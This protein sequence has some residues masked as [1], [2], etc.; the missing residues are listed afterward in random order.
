MKFIKLALSFCTALALLPAS[1]FAQDEESLEVIEARIIA[2]LQSARSDIAYTDFKT[3]AIEG[4]YQI[5][6]SGSTVLYV[7]EDGEHF[8][9]GEL[10]QIQPGGFVNATEVQ[11][12]EERRIQLASLDTDSMIIFPAVGESKGVLNVFTDVTC[13]YCRKL[14]E[15]I[16]E[17]NNAGI[18]I[19]YLAYPR[20][21]IERDG[22]QTH[23]YTETAKAWCAEDRNETMTQLKLGAAVPG[24]LCTDNPVADHYALGRAFGVTGTP[25]VVLPDGTLSPGYRTTEGYLDL[26]GVSH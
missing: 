8:F 16:A 12:A 13:G 2:S 22:L 11:K 14:H 26:L 19:R 23:E 18:E 1:A 3:S 20:S 4:Y 15:Q 9:A 6:A 5:T 7:S 17:M 10:Y 21:G 24:E 25:A